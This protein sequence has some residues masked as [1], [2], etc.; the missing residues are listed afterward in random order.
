MNSDQILSQAAA[1]FDKAL[2]H[3]R[4]EFS[5]LQIGRAN[6]SLV[7][8]VPVAMY[9]V[10]Q[11]IKA[12]ASISVPEPRTLVIQPWDRSGLGAI[13]KAIVGTGLGLNPVNDGI[14]V[15][16]NIPP[17]TEE[18]RRDLTRIVDKLAEEARIAIRTARQDAHNSLKALKADS[19][20]TEDDWRGA[21]KKL[22][23]KVD[24][25]NVK[26]DEASKTKEQDVMTV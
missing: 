6:P 13:E 1:E 2:A 4:D 21:D 11:P 10:S 9:G 3:L 22:Q 20:I 8:N 12:L 26:I 7:E 5:R 18:R 15:R 16:I 14:V 25:L 19:T 17:L 24:A 23:E